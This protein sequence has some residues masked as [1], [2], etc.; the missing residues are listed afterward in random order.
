[1]PV[2]Q[3][4]RFPKTRI[5]WIG[6]VGGVLAFAVILALPVPQGLTQ[7]AALVL[8]SRF[9]E[10]VRTKLFGKARQDETE[11]LTNAANWRD[12]ENLANDLFV[13]VH[14][15]DGKILDT[16]AYEQLSFLAK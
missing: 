8:K 5:W 9:P 3:E 15:R 1:M 7:Q 6:L 16:R 4:T 2:E 10:S 11:Y 14:S 13:A 12:F